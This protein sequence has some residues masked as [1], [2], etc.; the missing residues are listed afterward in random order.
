MFIKII[1][2]SGYS[3][4]V[5][6]FFPHANLGTLDPF[7]LMALSIHKSL[8]LCI[9]PLDEKRESRGRIPAFSHLNPE[10]TTYFHSSSNVINQSHGP[11]SMEE[12][13]MLVEEKMI[14]KW[15]SGWATTPPFELYHR[16][17]HKLCWTFELNL[18]QPPSQPTH[19]H[20]CMVPP[21]PHDR[22]AGSLLISIS[23]TMITRGLPD[24]FIPHK[25]HE[26]L[27]RMHRWVSLWLNTPFS[28]PAATTCQHRA[29]YRMS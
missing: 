24:A 6:S 26:K 23:F 8:S 14:E 11:T 19:N 18:P 20:I 7:N 9:W 28:S 29:R 10:V 13:R 16:K 22:L 5:H 3:Y 17:A 25:N 12:G 21:W 15:F 1:V 27:N 2:W 4:L